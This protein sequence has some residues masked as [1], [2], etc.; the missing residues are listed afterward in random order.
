MS[1][2]WFLKSDAVRENLISYLRTLPVSKGLEIRIHKANKTPPQR[3][4]WH[5]MVRIIS[6]DV[7]KTEAALKEELK[8][9]WLPVRE[10]KRG[11]GKIV[12]LPKPTEDLTK[13]EYS[14]LIERTLALAAFLGITIPS[15]YHMG[16]EL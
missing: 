13:E 8:A 6:E 12:L 3:A 10:H 15:P 14:E 16:I 1:S 4:Y 9:E 11:D 7:G 5:C 2:H